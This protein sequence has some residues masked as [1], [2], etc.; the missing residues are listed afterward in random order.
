MVSSVVPMA[1]RVKPST[2]KSRTAMRVRGRTDPRWFRQTRR[3]T[4][5]M[6]TPAGSEISRADG[7][8][9]R[10]GARIHGAARR[11][12]SERHHDAADA[13]EVGREVPGGDDHVVRIEVGQAEPRHAVG[14]WL[15]P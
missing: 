13:A 3:V 7:G 12:R 4:A 14:E 8:R 11:L 5:P 15:Q 9:E 6:E 10:E 2:E 1:T